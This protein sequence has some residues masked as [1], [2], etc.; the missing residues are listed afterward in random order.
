MIADVSIVKKER[1][2]K[3]P[4]SVAQIK[5]D[6]RLTV[7][8]PE[9]NPFQLNRVINTVLGNFMPITIDNVKGTTSLR[10]CIFY[11]QHEAFT[12]GIDSIILF[13]LGH[14]TAPEK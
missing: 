12:I 10:S 2:L 7:K 6:L 14:I 4:K 11:T 8:N 1:K 13:T 9:P 3:K 5:Y